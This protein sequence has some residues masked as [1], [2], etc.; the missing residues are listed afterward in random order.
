MHWTPVRFL[1]NWCLP[2]ITSI[3]YGVYSAVQRNFLSK[4]AVCSCISTYFV[5]L[6][7]VYLQNRFVKYNKNTF[8]YMNIYPDKNNKTLVQMCCK[9]YIVYSF[10]LTLHHANF[11][12]FKAKQVLLRNFRYFRSHAVVF[13][14]LLQADL[15]AQTHCICYFYCKYKHSNYYRYAFKQ[16][17]SKSINR[18]M[19]QNNG[20]FLRLNFLILFPVRGKINFNS[21]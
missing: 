8:L 6:F 4:E 18:I 11:G 3:V 9:A 17:L 14:L 19:A 20:Y 10:H 7:L 1:L 21:S 15:K 2:Q 12:Q 5:I 16:S 13:G